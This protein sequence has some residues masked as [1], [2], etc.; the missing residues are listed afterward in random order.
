MHLPTG[1]IQSITTNPPN[2]SAIQEHV[3]RHHGAMASV[4][5]AAA[6]LLTSVSKGS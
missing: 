1:K 2:S 3:N 4:Q 6:L 5:L